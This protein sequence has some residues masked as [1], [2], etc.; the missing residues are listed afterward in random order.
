M[1]FFLSIKVFHRIAVLFLLTQYAQTYLECHFVARYYNVSYVVYTSIPFFSEKK[2]NSDLFVTATMI[3]SSG[4]RN[5]SKVYKK[6]IRFGSDCEAVVIY[7]FTYHTQNDIE[8]V[9]K[10]TCN[11]ATGVFF[12]MWWKRGN[13]D[14][15][16]Y[17]WKRSPALIY[18]FSPRERFPKLYFSKSRLPGEDYQKLPLSVSA[19]DVLTRKWRPV[20]NHMG[21]P[22]FVLLEDMC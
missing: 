5:F 8:S 16:Y 18:I 11:S 7:D 9:F 6:L 22:I 20:E 12:L 4:S 2:V 14:I 17:D 15:Y 3:S 1:A 19:L 10:P 13:P 21:N